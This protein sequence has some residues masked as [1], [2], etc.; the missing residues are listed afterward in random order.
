MPRNAVRSSGA[1][2]P[3]G[4]HQVTFLDVRGQTL[5]LTLDG[6]TEADRSEAKEVLASFKF[7][8]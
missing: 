8:K 7:P 4:K 1:D 3:R 2:I 6:V 5:M